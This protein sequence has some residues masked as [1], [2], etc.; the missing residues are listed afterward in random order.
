MK[1]RQLIDNDYQ[2]N[3]F[4]QNTPETVGQVIL[5][6]LLLMRGEWFIDSQE[7]TPYYQEIFGHLAEHKGMYDLEIQARIL[8]TPGVQEIQDYVSEIDINRK[9]S[10]NC[11][12]FTDYGITQFTGQI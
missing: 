3:R 9:L 10:I 1:V 11:S 7:G 4:I 12:V 2:L 8:G 6:R 5:T